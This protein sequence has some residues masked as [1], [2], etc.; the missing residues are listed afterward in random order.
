[1]VFAHPAIRS[2]A[3]QPTSKHDRLTRPIGRRPRDRVFAAIWMAAR[4]RG[5]VGRNSWIVRCVKQPLP[6]SEGAGLA[7][8]EPRNPLTGGAVRSP[9]ID[10]A[11]GVIELRPDN[12]AVAPLVQRDTRRSRGKPPPTSFESRGIESASVH[13][14]QEIRTE[15]GDEKR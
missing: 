14:D 2:G 11:H 3:V 4:A 13:F 6:T 7:V 12:R 15:A 9:E 8:G 5:A 10:D 1:V